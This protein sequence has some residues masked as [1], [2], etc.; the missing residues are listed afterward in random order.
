MITEYEKQASAFMD[1]NVI[2]III[3]TAIVVG[4]IAAWIF[5]EIKPKKRVIKWNRKPINEIEVYDAEE[6]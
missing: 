6:L 5:G 2:A 1:L 4:F 3:I